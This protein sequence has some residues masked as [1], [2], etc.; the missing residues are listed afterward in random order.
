MSLQ[1]ERSEKYKYLVYVGG[2]RDS[3]C[4]ERIDILECTNGNNFLI[5]YLVAFQLGK[6]NKNS[7]VAPS[8]ISVASPT[9]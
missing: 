6:Y 3:G 8:H 1:N 5:S 4:S 7:T 2:F 9:P